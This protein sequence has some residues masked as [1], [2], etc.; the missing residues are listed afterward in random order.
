MTPTVEE[1]ARRVA[2][3]TSLCSISREAPWG[4]CRSQRDPELCDACEQIERAISLAV[5]AVLDEGFSC[6]NHRLKDEWER[7]VLAAAIKELEGK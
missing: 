3:K 7:I 1:L 4:A 2:T 6:G 5:R